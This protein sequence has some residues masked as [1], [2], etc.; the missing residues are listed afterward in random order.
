MRTKMN[1][2]LIRIGAGVLGL[3]LGSLILMEILP[4][5]PHPLVILVIVCLM[6]F[7][8]HLNILSLLQKE[9]LE[10]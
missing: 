9:K 3:L 8:V 6:Y 2:S 4:L 1:K 10:Q 7:N 5:D